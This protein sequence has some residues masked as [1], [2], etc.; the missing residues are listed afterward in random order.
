MSI[1]EHRELVPIVGLFVNLQSQPHAH[2]RTTAVV[3]VPEDTL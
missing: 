1:L 3:K 2:L